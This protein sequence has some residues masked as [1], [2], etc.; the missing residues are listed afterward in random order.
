M[1]ERP[2]AIFSGR[3]LFGC[4][5]QL[6]S[7]NPNL[8]LVRITAWTAGRTAPRSMRVGASGITT[9]S[10]AAKAAFTVALA[11]PGVA[12]N[13]TGTPFAPGFLSIRD[14]IVSLSAG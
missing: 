6:L 3:G 13:S 12:R 11:A 9:K 4:G 5:G 1:V 8:E 14:L 2:V 7:T 10:E